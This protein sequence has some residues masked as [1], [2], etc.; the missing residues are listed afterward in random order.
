MSGDGRGLSPAPTKQEV[1]FR[2]VAIL[3]MLVGLGPPAGLGEELVDA[4]LSRRTD[5]LGFQWDMD[6]RGQISNGS[7]GQ[8][9]QNTD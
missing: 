1:M 3:L 2:S 6:R 9:G 7:C 5:A 4:N 8:H